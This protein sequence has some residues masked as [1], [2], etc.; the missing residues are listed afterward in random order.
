MVSRASPACVLGI[1][2]ERA[3]QL[4]AVAFAKRRVG[5]RALAED[6]V[7]DGRAV[8]SEACD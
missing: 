1:G 6:C 8:E 4:D 7:A 5:A 3:R 2:D